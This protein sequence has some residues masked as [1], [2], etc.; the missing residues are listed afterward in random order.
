MFILFLATAIPIF[1]L[2]GPIVLFLFGNA[3]QPAS[4]L[5]CLFAIR[6]L[7]TNF[8]VAK[9]LF[10]T[11]ENLFKYSMFTAIVGSLANVSLNYI[12]IPRYASIGAIWAMIISFIITIFIVDVF[13]SSLRKNL[14]IMIEAMLT[15]W[16]LRIRY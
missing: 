11:N 10:I 8:G 2:A 3:Y 6:L 1:F 15:P 9:S 16:K 14:N 13:F 5:L 12:L 7:F 4:G